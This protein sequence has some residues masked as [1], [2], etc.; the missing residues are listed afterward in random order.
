A[1][2]VYYTLKSE[3]VKAMIKLLHSLYCEE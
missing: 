2:T 1:Q 3:E